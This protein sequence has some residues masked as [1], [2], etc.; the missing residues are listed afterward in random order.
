MKNLLKNM[1]KHSIRQKY[2]N[3]TKDNKYLYKK[4]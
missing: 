1:R 3:L 4:Y 2:V